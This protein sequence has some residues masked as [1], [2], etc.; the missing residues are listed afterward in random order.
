MLVS[1]QDRAFIDFV[2]FKQVQQTTTTYIYIHTYI[3]IY[4]HFLHFVLHG[5]SGGSQGAHASRKVAGSPKL[6]HICLP[7][8]ASGQCN[9][10]ASMHACMHVYVWM[11]VC[12]YMY[13]CMYACMHVVIYV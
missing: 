2:S 7:W 4:I 5:H 12:V 8:G 9:S 1:V 3:Y 10:E 11:C 6:V 13:V